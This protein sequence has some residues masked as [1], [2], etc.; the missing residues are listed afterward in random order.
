MCFLFMPSTWKATVRTGA[1]HGPR[2]AVN[3]GGAKEQRR[4][5]E[6]LEGDG[7]AIFARTRKRYRLGLSKAHLPV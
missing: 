5:K 6:Q 2:N 7:V 4:A 1:P 3:L